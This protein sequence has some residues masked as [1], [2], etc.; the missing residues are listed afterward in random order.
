[1]KGFEPSTPAL[2]TRC[3]P[4]ELHPHKPPIYRVSTSVSSAR[5]SQNRRPADRFQDGG[6]ASILDPPMSIRLA[7]SDN[8]FMLEILLADLPGFCL[9]PAFQPHFLDATQIE[10]FEIVRIPS[11]LISRGR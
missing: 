10:D 11:G 4:A 6:P 2:R 9:N 7:L 8:K 1:M 5:L 3:S